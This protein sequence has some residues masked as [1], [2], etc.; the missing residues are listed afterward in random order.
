MISQPNAVATRCQEHAQ[1][2]LS[3]V[4]N[5][6]STLRSAGA[7]RIKIVREKSA[8]RLDAIIMFVYSPQVILKI[9]IY[10]TGLLFA[11]VLF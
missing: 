7:R 1:H 2:L 6:W 4:T 3:L 8:A 10:V 5:V 9:K 11:H